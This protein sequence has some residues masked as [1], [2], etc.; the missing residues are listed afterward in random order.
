MLAKLIVMITIDYPN[1]AL[2][3]PKWPPQFRDVTLS[4]PP[5]NLNGQQPCVCREVVHYLMSGTVICFRG[6]NRYQ[7]MNEVHMYKQL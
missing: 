5:P 7:S 6:C 4:P 3:I 1:L 2:K